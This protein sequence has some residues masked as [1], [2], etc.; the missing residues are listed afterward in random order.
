MFI[1]LFVPPSPLTS[2]MTLWCL[3]WSFKFFTF[4]LIIYPYFITSPLHATHNQ[5]HISF[6]DVCIM[7]Y[8]KPFAVIKDILF[9]G[10]YF[11]YSS[12]KLHYALFA[13]AHLGLGIIKDMISE[14]TLLSILL[15]INLLTH[16]RKK[17]IIQ[18]SQTEIDPLR[19]ICPPCQPP[20]PR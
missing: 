13:S 9:A 1:T 16:S 4:L 18:F 6:H 17:E 14:H 5:A 2:I 20:Y 19:F 11:I 3:F 7:Q 15:N 12:H 8:A 10:K